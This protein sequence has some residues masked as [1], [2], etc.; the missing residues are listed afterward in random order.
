MAAFK[1]SEFEYILSFKPPQSM[2]RPC[3]P[4]VLKQSGG[5]GHGLE[6][7][8]V[9]HRGGPFTVENFHYILIRRRGL[10]VGVEDIDGQ[11]RRFSTDLRKKPHYLVQSHAAPQQGA[12][13][14]RYCRRQHLSQFL[15]RPRFSFDASTAILQPENDR[16][17]SN[18]ARL[19]MVAGEAPA[20]RKQQK[21]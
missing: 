4:G 1:R 11:R 6:T 3:D 7:R 16:A 14:L 20:G 18:V 15:A 10:Y 19:T 2:L 12:A 13:E 9:G 8:A 21:N 5:T 17:Q